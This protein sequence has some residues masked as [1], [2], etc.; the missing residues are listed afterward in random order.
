[1]AL[2][3][4]GQYHAY[5]YFESNANPASVDPLPYFILTSA[6]VIR[7]DEKLS[8]A[9]IQTGKDIISLYRNHFS[10]L[11]QE[12][13]PLTSYT[14]DLEHVLEAYMASTDET[15]YYTIMTQPCL[16]HYYTRELME[17][18]FR[19]EIPDRDDL[20]ALSD[21]RFERL[22][23]LHQNY[24]T[25]FTEQ[26]IRQFAADGVAADLPPD[27][28]LPGNLSLRLRLLTSLRQDI[29]SDVIIGCI[30]KAGQL[31]IPSY[32]T[33]TADPQFGLHIYAI[34]GFPAGSYTCNL[35]IQETSIGQSFCNFIKS[36]PGSRFVYPKEKTLSIL[37]EL[38]GQLQEETAK[39]E[40]YFAPAV[41]SPG[42][43]RKSPVPDAVSPGKPRRTAAPC[44]PLQ[45]WAGGIFWAGKSAPA[46]SASHTLPWIWWKREKTPLKS[47][48]PSLCLS[49]REN[50]SYLSPEK[51]NGI[52]E[53][54][55]V[56]SERKGNCFPG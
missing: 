45:F 49:D 34:L 19:P 14:S 5:Y 26:G 3:S 38:I 12:C 30:A 53:R 23:Q 13:Q 22:R 18:N 24:Y 44:R 20:I 8:V 42:K 10:Q 6:C 31:D 47:S 15:G 55:C 51:K 17:Q 27:L 35:H 54:L 48:F 25:I 52:S 21:R 9:Q 37:D 4:Q 16:G 36:L 28:V 39:N 11:I 33:L 1:M 29:A 56:L 41:W 2:V 40:V 7:V 32:L 50:R 46:V 43:I